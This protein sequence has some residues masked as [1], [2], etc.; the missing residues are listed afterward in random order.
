MPP[1]PKYTKEEITDSAFELV[2]TDGPDAL[3]AR[4]V[5][6]RL[7]VSSSPI[8]TFFKDMDELKAEVVN[9]AKSCFDEYM[10][11]AEKYYPSFKKHGMQFVRFASDEPQLFKLLFMQSAGSEKKFE[12]AIDVIPFGKK[13]DIDIIKRDYHATEEEAH[14]LFNQMWIYTYGL[15]V[16]CASGVCA[17]SDEEISMRLGEIFQGMTAV[18]SADAEKT[19]AENPSFLLPFVKESDAY[20]TV[21][22]SGPDFSKYA[23]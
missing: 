23:L 15:C 11:V 1:K 19:D 9:R 22:K 5:G 10:V 20:E 13:E 3:T 21:K 4:E 18:I 17:F 7:G 16:L 12:N 14:R 6:K 8:F 2:R